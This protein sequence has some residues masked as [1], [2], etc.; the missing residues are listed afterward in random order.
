MKSIQAYSLTTGCDLSVS[1]S[2][3][4]YGWAW[5]ER[6]LTLASAISFP[7]L[8][9]SL[10]NSQHLRAQQFD[11]QYLYGRNPE[12]KVEWLFKSHIKTLAKLNICKTLNAAKL[13]KATFLIL[14]VFCKS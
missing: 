13:H 5:D 9:K 14:G 6:V 11:V 1:E 2:Q 7:E 4:T 3:Q 12:L 8:Q 10:K